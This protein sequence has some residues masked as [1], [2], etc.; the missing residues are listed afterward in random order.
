MT[1]CQCPARSTCDFLYFLSGPYGV[2]EARANITAYVAGVEGFLIA[3][4]MWNDPI[5]PGRSFCAHWH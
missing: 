2:R 1:R 3:F 5:S 4:F